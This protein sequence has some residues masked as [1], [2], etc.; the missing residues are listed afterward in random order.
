MIRGDFGESDVEM[1]SP[2]TIEKFYQEVK[3]DDNYKFGHWD[4]DV[5]VELKVEGGISRA[6]YILYQNSLDPNLSQRLKQA[7]SWCCIRDCSCSKKACCCP[8]PKFK[9]GCPDPPKY[10]ILVVFVCVIAF[11]LESDFAALIYFITEGCLSS[12]DPVERVLSTYA[13][14]SNSLC[15]V[16]LFLTVDQCVKCWSH[17]FQDDQMRK[18]DPRG[19]ESCMACRCPVMTL[20]AA[21][22][23]VDFKSTVVRR[24]MLRMRW[25]MLVPFAR[26]LFIVVQF[27]N[28]DF[29]SAS[30][31][32][33]GDMRREKLQTVR[34][35][36]VLGMVNT[37]T[38][39][40]PNI[41]IAIAR[42]SSG[43]GSSLDDIFFI[44]NCIS[45]S[46]TAF[47]M[48]YGVLNAIVN[49]IDTMDKILN[50]VAEAEEQ[51]L[52]VAKYAN[53][54]MEALYGMNAQIFRCLRSTSGN[55]TGF[56][57]NTRPDPSLRTHIGPSI[58][59]YKSLLASLRAFVPE[60]VTMWDTK[61]T[62]VGLLE[63]MIKHSRKERMIDS[64]VEDSM[65][66]A[67]W[68]LHGGVYQSMITYSFELKRACNIA[69]MDWKS[70]AGNYTDFLANHE[71][72][73]KHALDHMTI[74]VVGVTAELDTDLSHAYKID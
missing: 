21:D 18:N 45:L 44:M 72:M 8:T 46:F 12:N 4:S 30:K 55:F 5:A 53:S 27:G 2:M 1:T 35:I 36:T 43:Q 64:T 63:E 67:L 31:K 65:E 56:V 23:S 34:S 47:S 57:Q 51:Q 6:E 29:K 32:T 17:K 54:H 9:C 19:D 24:Q 66:I 61:T 49:K 37:L 74:R 58:S 26:M 71:K 41:T 10:F 69:N 20:G 59:T 70:F 7:K 25:Y 28:V 15:Y 73:Q 13:L 38:L 60:D 62:L 39:T 50:D 11:M 33:I 42:R 3:A 22:N 40:I 68:E 14:I 48:C 52:Q 16:A